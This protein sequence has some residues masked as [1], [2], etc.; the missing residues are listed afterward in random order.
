MLRA[1]ADTHAVIWYIFADLRLSVTARTRIEQIAAEGNQVAFSSITLAEIVYLSERGR[2]NSATFDL[3]LREVESDD[4]LLV[5]I[6][7]DRNIA[8]TLRQVDRSQIPDLPDRIIAATALYLN[9]PVIS[10]DRRIQLS[11]IDTIW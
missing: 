6:P 11:S 5:E 10:R 7:F 9:V 2:I 1:L 8:L 3:F 4:A